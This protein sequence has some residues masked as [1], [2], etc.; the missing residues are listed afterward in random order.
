MGEQNPLIIEDILPIIGAY[1]PLYKVPEIE[2]FIHNLQTDNA[3]LEEMIKVQWWEPL[4][5]DEYSKIF[6]QK[7]P[8]T[9]DKVSSYVR[10]MYEENP[11]PRYRYANYT[12]ASIAANFTVHI[13]NE[14]SDKSIVFEENLLGPDYKP[15]ILIAGCG[16]GNQIIMA[17]RYKNGVI[18]GIDLSA[19][20][21]AYAKRKAEEYN[22]HNVDFRL[23]N[24]LD[25]DQA[26]E[27]QFDIIE[28]GGVL[29]H[30]ENPESGSQ[31]T[32]KC[33]KP[34]GFIKIGLYSKK[35]RKLILEAR[36][37]V[38]DNML[39]NDIRGIRKFKESNICFNLQ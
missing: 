12:H 13:A 2:P 15:S 9:K 37:F 20:S 34:N 24:I 29:H 11:Y 30:M 5:E 18:T 31:I 25:V 1:K 19:T 21:L 8:I 22:M 28:C 33:L 36:K 17:S 6:Y 38:E 14:S 27:K 35:A 32:I 39:Y 16:T 26:F 10:D 23:M 3:Y 4:K 7:Q